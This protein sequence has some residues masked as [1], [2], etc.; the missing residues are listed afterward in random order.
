[1]P[2][3]FLAVFAATRW[4][5][6]MP[7]DFSAAYALMFC[8]GV[9]FPG[10]AAWTAPFLVMLATD[11][12]LNLWYQFGKGWSVFTPSLILYL[13]GNYVGYAILVAFGRCLRPGSRLLSLVCGGVLGALV[14]YLVTNTAS[15]LLNP[16]RNPEYTR[17]L[18]GWITALTKGA[19]GY[20]ETWTFFRNTLL[21]GGLFTALFAGAWKL[22]PAESP[23]E[24]GEGES[25]ADP[26]A[27]PSEAQ[28]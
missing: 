23:L 16:F 14:F 2:W 3:V 4:P 10:R 12:A 11:L 8:A 28:A 18:A 1:M 15:W 6:L 25:P 26:E 22:A 24:K 21:G 5:G 20:P 9:F 19:G 27:E 7:E 17:T 13:A